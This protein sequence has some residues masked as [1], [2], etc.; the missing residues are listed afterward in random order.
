MSTQ[1]QTQTKETASSFFKSGISGTPAQ[2]GVSKMDTP[3]DSKST[4]TVSDEIVEQVKAVLKEDRSLMNNLMRALLP[5]AGFGAG[6]A[7]VYLMMVKPKDKEI[8]K[9]R[10][11][12]EELRESNS[13]YRNKLRGLE[14][15]ALRKEQEQPRLARTPIAYLD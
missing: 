2:E 12:L 15:S 7:A 1:Q 10:A 3:G 8:A 5:L 11:E 6:A 9:L 14:G 4:A 13:S